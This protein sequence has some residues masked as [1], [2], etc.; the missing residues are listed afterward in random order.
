MVAPVGANEE[1]AEAIA[2][3]LNDPERLKAYGAALQCR[4]REYYRAGAVAD[5]YGALYR[6]NFALQ[7][8][9]A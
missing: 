4:V 8:E 6:R 3:L 2:T 1:I 5:A 7:T 9:V